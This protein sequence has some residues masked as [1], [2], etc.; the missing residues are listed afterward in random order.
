MSGLNEV[1]RGPIRW[2]PGS[3]YVYGYL[4]TLPVHSFKIAFSS[5]STELYSYL[6]GT[7]SATYDLAD[8]PAAMAEAER[9]LFSWVEQAGL[10]KI[11]E[12]RS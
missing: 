11:R 6:T 5:T 12:D 3:L 9:I 10:D 8:I 2:S 7:Q 4:G 1:K